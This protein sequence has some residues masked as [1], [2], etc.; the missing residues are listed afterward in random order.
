MDAEGIERHLNELERLTGANTPA[1]GRCLP[2]CG[3]QAGAQAKREPACP[4]ATDGQVA[5]GHATRDIENRL[6]ALRLRIVYL[7][8]DSEATR[9]ESRLLRQLL[10]AAR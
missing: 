2:T 1:F 10:E 5:P 4:D 8:L 9:R 6:E 3:W 7:L